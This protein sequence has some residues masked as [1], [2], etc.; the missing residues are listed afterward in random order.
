MEFFRNTQYSERCA[1]I[2][3]R[4]KRW[5]GVSLGIAPVIFLAIPKRLRVP[6]DFVWSVLDSAFSL[7]YFPLRARRLMIIY[8]PGTRSYMR[9]PHVS[10]IVA[11]LRSTIYGDVQVSFVADQRNRLG[12]P[13]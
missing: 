3:A 2:H 6:R 4:N 12:Y 10:R 13:E 1:I 8:S 11:L 7:I 5:S 9:I